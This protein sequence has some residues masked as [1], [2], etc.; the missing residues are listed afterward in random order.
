MS[1]RMFVKLPV[2]DARA[3]TEAIIALSAESRE[4]EDL[5]SMYGHGFQDPDGHIR[6]LVFMEPGAVPEG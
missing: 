4:P 3:A 1:G 5:G 6:E 2:A